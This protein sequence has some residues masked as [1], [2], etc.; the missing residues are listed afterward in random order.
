M[1]VFMEGINK[2]QHIPPHQIPAAVNDPIV[3]GKSDAL[4]KRVASGAL[5]TLPSNIKEIRSKTPKIMEKRVTTGQADVS[6]EQQS[7][8]R[9]SFQSAL[10]GRDKNAPTHPTVEL[11]KSAPNGPFSEIQVAD[12]IVPSGTGQPNELQ[13]SA[14]NVPFSEIQVADPI[15][16]SEKG[17]PNEL[18]KKR[19]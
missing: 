17:L 18:Q 13:K 5:S 3:P 10:G 16:P 4:Q 14:P 2:N 11:Q 15:V 6:T 1:E 12:P 19:A 8:I 7:K 9:N